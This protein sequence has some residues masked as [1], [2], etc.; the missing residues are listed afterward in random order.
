MKLL[1]RLL[2]L[3][4]YLLLA[5]GCASTE[6]FERQMNH[7]LGQPISRIQAHF[8]YN[9][10]E[11]ELEN[12]RVAYTWTWTQSDFTPGHRTPDIIRTYKSNQG[13]YTYFIPGSY[14]PP[15]YYEYACEFTFITDQDSRAIDWRAHGN[16][17]AF[18]PGVGDIMR[19]GKK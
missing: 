17:C 11:R 12:N 9:Y 5:A 16:G 4:A 10:I 3:L 14:F 13:S 7:Y 18:Y 6:K 8:G 15:A 19:P 2:T 1:H